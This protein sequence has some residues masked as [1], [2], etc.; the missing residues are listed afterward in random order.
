[1]TCFLFIF[2]T[3]KFKINLQTN[4]LPSAYVDLRDKK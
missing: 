4:L 1:M 2:D 3:H